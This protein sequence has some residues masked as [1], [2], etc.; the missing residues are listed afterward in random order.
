MTPEVLWSG[1]QAFLFRFQGGF[2]YV[3]VEF[4]FAVG[5]AKEVVATLKPVLEALNADLTVALI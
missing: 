1:L 4:L 3:S 5:A 2:F